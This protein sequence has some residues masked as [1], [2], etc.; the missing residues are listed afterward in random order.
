MKKIIG[1]KGRV[2]Y[3]AHKELIEDMITKGHPLT[4]VHTKLKEEGKVS[5]SYSQF[6]YIVRQDNG[7]L[8]PVYKPRVKKEAEKVGETQEKIE[9]AKTSQA[10]AP[11]I[12]N[13]VKKLPPKIIKSENETKEPSNFIKSESTAFSPACFDISELIGDE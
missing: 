2:E 8:Y 6:S 12:V 10:K 4:S 3:L 9:E 7:Q 13:E 5:I 1:G 11:I